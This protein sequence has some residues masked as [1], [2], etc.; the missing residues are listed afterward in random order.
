MT[1]DLPVGMIRW[2][3][4]NTAHQS[5]IGTIYLEKEKFKSYLAVTDDTVDCC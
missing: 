5:S 3:H 1:N 2:L 4:T